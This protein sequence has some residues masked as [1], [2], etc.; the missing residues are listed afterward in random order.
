MGTGEMDI[1]GILK[2]AGFVLM[3][4]FIVFAFRQGRK[5]KPDLSSGNETIPGGT[6]GGGGIGMGS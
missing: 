1:W 2:L 4:A 6:D 3:I 5:V